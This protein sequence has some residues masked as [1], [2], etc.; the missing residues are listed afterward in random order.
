MTPHDQLE[1]DFTA[2]ATTPRPKRKRKPAGKS[3]QKE[4]VIVGTP[5][6]RFMGGMA[7]A[8]YRDGLR[9][10]AYDI[11][12]PWYYLLGGRILPAAELKARD[13]GEPHLPKIPKKADRTKVLREHQR[14]LQAELRREIEQYEHTARTGVTGRDPDRWVEPWNDSAG[15]HFLSWCSSLGLQVAHITATKGYLRGLAKVMGHAVPDYSTSNFNN[16]DHDDNDE[17]H[18]DESDSGDPAQRP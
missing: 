2:K 16:H 3:A 1:L 7:A 10:E 14:K 17:P 4:P 5:D 13:M 9:P 18:P 11:G 12:H 15:D 8:N 6:P